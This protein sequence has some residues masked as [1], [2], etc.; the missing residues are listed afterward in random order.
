MYFNYIYSSNFSLLNKIGKELA[1]RG[2][3]VKITRVPAGHCLK[4]N[5][6]VKTLNNVKKQII[7]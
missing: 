1:V 6:S 3:K 4:A 2:Y 5:A 7:N